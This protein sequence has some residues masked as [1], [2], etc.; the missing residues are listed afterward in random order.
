M[1]HNDNRLGEYDTY[2]T[3]KIVV[4]IQPSNKLSEID[5]RKDIV[6]R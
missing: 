1:T 4:E 3:G 5:V 2:T 6:K